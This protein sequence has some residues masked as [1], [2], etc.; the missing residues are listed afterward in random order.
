MQ[1]RM[2]RLP[3]F[4]SAISLLAGA[5]CARGQ[6]VGA[7]PDW[8]IDPAPYRTLVASNASE[9]VLENG[10]ARRVF[11]LAP[12]AATI[13]LQNL[14]SGEHYLR[15]IAPEARVKIDGV[16]YAVGGLK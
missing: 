11:R 14:T 10:L 3:T 12:N 2:N 8:M 6:V 9:L 7:K 16:D 1:H 13:D 15:A 5:W 4:A